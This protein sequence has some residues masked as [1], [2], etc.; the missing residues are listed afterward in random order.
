MALRK[1]PVDN[2]VRYIPISEKTKKG[3]SK[4]KAGSLPRIQNKNISQNNKKFPKI[5]Q[6]K[7]SNN[8]NE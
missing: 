6:H 3:E 8:L 7:D 1:M 5:V 4:P 2:S